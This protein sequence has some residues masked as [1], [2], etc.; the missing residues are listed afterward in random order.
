VYFIKALTWFCRAKSP[1][2]KGAF[3]HPDG[4]R[5]YLKRYRMPSAKQAFNPAAK[6]ENIGSDQKL[7][8]A[9]M[10][11]LSA[12]TSSDY[13]SPMENILALETMKE[14]HDGSGLGLMLKDMAGPF[15]DF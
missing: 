7:R 9:S 2:K 15:P 10:C 4:Q 8:G 1:F 3:F 5:S 12:I 6:S 14:G 13:I 11:R